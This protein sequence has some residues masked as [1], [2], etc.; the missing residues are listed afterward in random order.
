MMV[1]MWIEE[2]RDI[3]GTNGFQAS[4]FTS[5]LPSG[6]PS[7]I[8]PYIMDHCDGGADGVVKILFCRIKYNIKQAKT[9]LLGL[10]NDLQLIRDHLKTCD[11]PQIL[12]QALLSHPEFMSVLVDVLSRLLTTAETTAHAPAALSCPLI[13][14][15]QYCNI[16]SY[17]CIF[18][19][20]NTTFVALVARLSRIHGSDA[21]LM[22][23]THEILVAV[24]RFSIY[25]T[26]LRAV[27]R[28]MV[29]ALPGGEMAYRKRGGRSPMGQSVLALGRAG[30][31]WAHM[32]HHDD[33]QY[34]ADCGYPQVRFWVYSIYK[35]LRISVKYLIVR[36]YRHRSYFPPMLWVSTCSIL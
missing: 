9:D 19:L 1:S 23:P 32:Y 17:D 5:P 12:R 6:A 35:C 2:G 21:N 30:H 24:A 8:L 27:G 22:H 10:Q 13:I 16:R 15:S 33:L 7:N 20:A 28:N 3:S 4:R 29:L 31:Q 25:R 14:I 11:D 26:L 18:Q 36:T 34:S